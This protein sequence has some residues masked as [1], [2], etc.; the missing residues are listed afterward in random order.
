MCKKALIA[1]TVTTLIMLASCETV[2]YQQTPLTLPQKPWLPAIKSEQLEC[3][4]D[5]AYKNLVKRDLLRKQ[6]SEKLEAIIKSTHK[7]K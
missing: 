2:R 7:T 4:S 6:Y 3:L 1:V 5:D